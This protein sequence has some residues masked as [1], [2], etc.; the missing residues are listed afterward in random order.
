MSALIIINGQNHEI[1]TETP[2][3]IE[4]AFRSLNML[5]DAHLFLLNSRPVPMT[6]LLMDGEQVTAIRI[7]S[8]G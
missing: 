7:A 1:A 2:Q 3:S 5:P 6:R 8:G 4:L